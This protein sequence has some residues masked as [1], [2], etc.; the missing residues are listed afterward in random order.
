MP[1]RAKKEKLPKPPKLRKPRVG[2]AGRAGR[3]PAG[4]AGQK[5]T[6]KLIVQLGEKSPFAFPQPQGLTFQDLINFESTRGQRLGTRQEEKQPAIIEPARTNI[7]ALGSML[8]NPAENL[9]FDPNSLELLKSKINERELKSES[10]LKPIFTEEPSENIEIK[11]KKP[12]RKKRPVKA[13][14]TEVQPAELSTTVEE[15]FNRP[16]TTKSLFEQIAKTQPPTDSYPDIPPYPMEIIPKPK[17]ARR[18]KGVP[19]GS[20]KEKAFAEGVE[21][22]IDIG[23]PAGRDVQNQLLMDI[24]QAAGIPVQFRRPAMEAPIQSGSSRNINFA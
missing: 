24:Q 4:K 13:K 6:Q 1:P 3:A 21:Q 23:V 9:P 19:R 22:G 2:R 15:V 12:P 18:D 11:P 17:P 16:I 10:K 20:I 8:L 5:Q 14:I 7:A